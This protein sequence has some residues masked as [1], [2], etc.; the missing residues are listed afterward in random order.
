VL[1]YPFA[2]EFS[3]FGARIFGISSPTIM[4]IQIMQ[5]PPILLAPIFFA[6]SMYMSLSRIITAAGCVSF[7]KIRLVRLTKVFDWRRRPLLPHAGLRRSYPCIN[8]KQEAG[9]LGAKSYSHRIVLADSCL[10]TLHCRRCG[11]SSTSKADEC[12]KGLCV[13]NL[14]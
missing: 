9:R 1:T 13:G 6:A 11:V 14:F 2:V 5:T 12:Y 8:Q 3:G 7:S 4:S 10:W